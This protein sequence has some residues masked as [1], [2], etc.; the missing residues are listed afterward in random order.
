M[1]KSDG[2]VEPALERVVETKEEVESEVPERDGEKK[3]DCHTAVCSRGE[4]GV[5]S[6]NADYNLHELKRKAQ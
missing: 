5:Y 6:T 1:L 2:A 3:D 4:S